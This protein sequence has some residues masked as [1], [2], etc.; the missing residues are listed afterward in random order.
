MD[1]QLHNYIRNR[2]LVWTMLIKYNLQSSSW[3]IMIFKNLMNETTLLRKLKNL[4]KGNHR[5]LYY[6][7]EN[8]I[9]SKERKILWLVCRQK[10]NLTATWIKFLSRPGWLKSQEHSQLFRERGKLEPMKC[11]KRKVIKIIFLFKI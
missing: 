5:I 10:R 8:Q 3:M 1:D 6:R 9:K 11:I 4:W 2:G 7:V